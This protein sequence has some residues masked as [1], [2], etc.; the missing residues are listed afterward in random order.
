MPNFNQ[1]PHASHKQ[2]IEATD[3]AVVDV[4]VSVPEVHALGPV[5]I[6][7]SQVTNFNLIDERVALL[8]LINACALFASSRRTKF[9]AMV[10][11]TTRSPESIA[12]G[13]SVAQYLPNRYCKS[14]DRDIRADFDFPHEVF[15]NDKMLANLDNQHDGG[16]SSGALS[17]SPLASH[18]DCCPTGI[19][20]YDEFFV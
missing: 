11:F 5:L 14:K 8:F 12:A 15:A 20:Q 10:L 2:P 17:G 7:F 4:E 9:S 1:C 16:F 6:V 13:S 3:E 18:P 19:D